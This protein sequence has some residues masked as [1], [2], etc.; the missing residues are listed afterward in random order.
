MADMKSKLTL[1][2]AAALL[3]LAPRAGAE[4]AA[5]KTISRDQ[6]KT[7]VV[8]YLQSKGYKTESAEFALEDNP[9]EKDLPDYYLFDAYYNTRTKLTSLGAYAVDRKSAALW[10]R[11]SCEQVS[12]DALE[13][14]QSRLRREVAGHDIIT[15]SEAQASSSPCY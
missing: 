1:A 10:Q 11:V 3:A 7:V 13:Q 14:V 15:P 12:S 2:L 8:A 6:A 9:D 4:P 5:A